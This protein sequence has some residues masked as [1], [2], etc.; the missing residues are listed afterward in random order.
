MNRFLIAVLAALGVVFPTNAQTSAQVEV[1]ADLLEQFDPARALETSSTA[2]RRPAIAGGV[3]QNGLFQHPRSVERPARVTY[4]I[5]L[6][7]LEPNDL[8][9]L[10]FDLALADGIQF[11]KGEDG[12]RFAVEIGGQRVFA[13]DWR[14]CRWESCGVDLTSFAGRRTELT[15]LVEARGNTTYDWAVWGNPRLLHFRAGRRPNL[16]SPTTHSLPIASGAFAVRAP[17][18]ARVRLRPDDNSAPLEW[19]V[20]S[21][22]ASPSGTAWLVKDFNLGRAGVLAWEMEKTDAA[23]PVFWIV[24]YPAQPKLRSLSGTQAL[25]LAG[26]TV[27]LRAEVKNEGR[28]RLAPPNAW[29]RMSAGGE[30][31]PPH[32]VPALNPQESWSTEWTWKTGTNAGPVF[33]VAQLIHDGTIDERTNSLELFGP[34]TDRY[35]LQNDS[36]KWEFIRADRGFAYAQVFARQDGEWTPVALWRPLIQVVSDTREGERTWE[37]RPERVRPMT[38]GNSGVAQTAEFSGSA[39]DADGV[40][41]QARLRVSLTPDQPLAHLQFEWKT[42]QARQVRA[43]RGPNVYVGEGTTGEAKSWGLFP[44]LE[45]LQGGE[46]SSNPRD[47]APPLDD[48]RTPHPHKIT[49]PMMAVT[50]GPESGRAPEHPDR[51]FT[52]DSLQDQATPAPRPSPAAHLRSDLTVALTWDP[53]QRWDGEHTFPTPRFASPN[54]DE[55]MRNHRLALFLPS[56]P[57]FV[58]EN[59]D[60]ATRPYLLAAGKPVTLEADLSISKGP[61]MAALG[62]WIRRTGGLPK[63]TPWP[64]TFQEELDVCRAGFLQ[65]VWDSAQEKFRHCI[66]W[67]GSHAPGFAALLWLDSQ[68]AEKPAAR[69]DSKKRVDLAAANMLSDG[70]PGLFTSKANCHIMEWEF[71]FLYGYLPE[72]MAGLDRQIRQ[73]IDS[74]RPDGGWRYQP[75]NA[76]Q[77]DLGRTGDSVLGTCA[78][79]SATLLRY[80]R[81]TGDADALAAGVKSLRFME[82]FRVPRGGQTWECPMYEPDILA[83]AY[84]IRAYHDG[85]RITGDTRWLHDA[86]SWAETGVPFVYLWTLPNRPMML[87]A[88][89]PVFGS[90]F[91][92]H[93]WLAVPVQWCGLVYAYHVLHLAQ[94]LETSRLAPTDSPLPL[95]LNFTPADWR[96]IVELITASGLHQQFADGERIGSY[97]DSISNFEQRNPAFLNPED[98]LV[99]VLALSGHDPDIKTQILKSDRGNLVVS[100]GANITALRQEDSAV[101]FE[102]RFFTAELSHTLVVG[103]KPREVLVNG[104]R[105]PESAQPARREAGWSWDSRHQRLYLA[106]PHAQPNVRVQVLY[107]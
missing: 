65:T 45:Y 58:D 67:A 7:P 4:P 23:K 35:V 74:Q 9:L 81:I 72:A 25:I 8:L 13:Q 5:A 106:V 55:G 47:F 54:F 14:E 82:N 57:D 16:A 59:A 3:K 102:L 2:I 85:F 104:N 51:F 88:T 90:T 99:N 79:R 76:E 98:I 73:L 39:Q 71:P 40:A 44:G 46:R 69:A 11:G 12:V 89:I 96:R 53:F 70:G 64:R 87:G 6:P 36:V 22:G 50:I 19:I 26:D 77:A 83:A 41:W 105:L 42:D 30:K 63:P 103:P 37:I 91:Y 80:A 78:N 43:L 66:G 27:T 52:P 107:P 68:V 21:A 84:A 97:P 31:L 24:P 95:A 38:T 18:G 20:P 33:L 29:V 56:V 86:V 28:G 34:P 1:I 17:V 61:A 101:G 92:S 62:E 10:A 100:S 49:V 32:T 75:A 60:R 94:E 15:L 93:S 48:R